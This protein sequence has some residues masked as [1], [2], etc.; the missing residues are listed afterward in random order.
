MEKNIYKIR[1]EVFI[2]N[3][4]D[5]NDDDWRVDLK[6]NHVYKTTVSELGEIY[7]CKKVILTNNKILIKE[8]VQAIDDEFL[9][10]IINNPSCEKIETES[11]CKNGDD[12]PSQGPYDNLCNI[13]YKII[14]PK[15]EPKQE[16]LKEVA[17]NNY[18]ECDVWTLEQAVVRRLAFINGAKSDAARDYWFKI[19]QQDKNK[20][21]EEDLIS[22]AHFYFKEEFNSTMQTSK[23]T[24]EVLQEWKEFKKK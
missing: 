20:Y 15:E 19:L 10:W 2:T 7:N 4:E 3:D 14:I 16:K 17:E 6:D 23:S 11:F 24:N 1:K 21:S 5:I 12:C 22:F 9:E 13:G 8:G 18:P